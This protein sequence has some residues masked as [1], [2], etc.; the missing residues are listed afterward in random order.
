MRTLIPARLSIALLALLF[1]LSTHAAAQPNQGPTR[2]MRIQIPAGGETIDLY[3]ES[4][5]LVIGVSDYTNGWP[6][7]PGVKR[8]I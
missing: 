6:S 2:G 3:D 5:A 1:V 7:L 4:H 8:D